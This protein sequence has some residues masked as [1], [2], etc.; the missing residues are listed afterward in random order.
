[1]HA[2]WTIHHLTHR[3][4]NT[5]GIIG[6][7]IPQFLLPVCSRPL[8]KVQVYLINFPSDHL[9]VPITGYF[10][11]CR[12]NSTPDTFEVFASRKILSS[13]LQIQV[14]DAD[15]HECIECLS[16]YFETHRV[17]YKFGKTISLQTEI[18][19]GRWHLQN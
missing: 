7:C 2:Q 10:F 1:M 8:L 5:W 18:M 16:S 9:H 14:L 6:H 4:Q 15:L 12:D 11:I 19:T 13:F 3:S 17:D